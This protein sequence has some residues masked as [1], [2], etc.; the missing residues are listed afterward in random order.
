M[1]STNANAAQVAPVAKKLNTTLRGGT[2]ETMR[3]VAERRKSGSAI[4][5]AV[6]EKVDADGKVLDRQRGDVT[7][8]KDLDA[9]N[10]EREKMV[11]KYISDGWTGGRAGGFGGRKPS[12]FD[13]ANAPKPSA[14]G[15]TPAP[16]KPAA[17]KAPAAAQASGKR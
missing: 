17:Q 8:H 5:F 2:G 12:A 11:A 9:A 6:F 3:V 15:A 13:R 10:A 1:G 4:A 16:A 14:A 7:E